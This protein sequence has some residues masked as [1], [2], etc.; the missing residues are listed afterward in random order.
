M[1]KGLRERRSYLCAGGHNGTLY[2]IIVFENDEERQGNSI[3]KYTEAD[4]EQ[5]VAMCQDDIV[6]PGI[7]FGDIYKGQIQSAIV[8]L[9]GG[10]LKTCFYGRMVLVGDSW[11]KVSTQPCPVSTANNDQIHPLGDW[12]ATT[13]FCLPLL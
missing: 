5:L 3:R 2:W 1:F 7:T 12:E 11:H 9:E 6:K 13:Q 4:R 10:V 8:P